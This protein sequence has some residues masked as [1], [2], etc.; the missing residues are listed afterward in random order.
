METGLKLCSLATAIQCDSIWKL[1]LESFIFGVHWRTWNTGC[2]WLIY[3]K[4]RV[5]YP[6]LPWFVSFSVTSS[7]TSCLSRSYSLVFISVY[8]FVP[9]MFLCFFVWNSLFL[10]FLIKRWCSFDRFQP[11]LRP[12]RIA[13]LWTGRQLQETG[14]VPWLK[15]GLHVSAY[16][17]WTFSYCGLLMLVVGDRGVC[18]FVIHVI[19]S[20]FYSLF[21]SHPL[22]HSICRP[23]TFLLWTFV[24][25]VFRCLCFLLFVVSPRP[26]P[27][28]CVFFFAD[29]WAFSGPPWLWH[30][31]IAR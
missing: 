27:L 8:S 13:G 24:F 10:L 17:C 2:H 18:V 31:P 21:L 15:E 30:S 28:F 29:Y 9:C 4:L 1:N 6:H 12:K 14:L 20:G 3:V 23:V 25:I 16:A 11:L 19:V 5:G 26:L 7:T 22:L